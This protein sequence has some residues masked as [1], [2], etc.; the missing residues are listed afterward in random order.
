MECAKEFL[1][2]KPELTAIVQLKRTDTITISNDDDNNNNSKPE[3]SNKSILI[4]KEAVK[5]KLQES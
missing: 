3:R 2:I 1:I 5:V 4:V